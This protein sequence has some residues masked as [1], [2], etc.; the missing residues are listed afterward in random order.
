MTGLA[1]RSASGAEAAGRRPHDAVALLGT[2][3]LCIKIY[4]LLSARAGRWMDYV[5]IEGALKLALW[6]PLPA[7]VLWI[8]HR[9]QDWSVVSAFGLDRGLMRGLAFGLIATVPMAAAVAFL[10][11]KALDPDLVLGSS[12]LGP[13]AEE[14]LFR[15][16][17]FA[18]LIR[19]AGWSMPAALVVSSI[20]FGLAHIRGVDQS[21]WNLVTGPNPARWEAS[22]YTGGPYTRVLSGGDVWMR[23][24]TTALP[25]IIERAL[26]Y[27]A[28][29]ALFAW[30]LY[31]WKFLWPAIALHGLMNFWWDLT[32]GEHAQ[33]VFRL[34]AMSVA[35]LIAV[36]LAIALTL[37]GTRDGA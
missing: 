30:V 20:V 27:A 34:D 8:L 11:T 31:R 28:G 6:A 23:D 36:A 4:W 9:R 16:F 25:M 7:L 33:L 26:P 2:T 19:R 18:Y 10:P 1:R 37:R 24:L 12:V 13:V 29:G 17:L 32:K 5:S 3:Y 15:G 22:S 21:I 14:I 35:Q